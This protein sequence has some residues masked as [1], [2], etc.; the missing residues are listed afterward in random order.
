LA[1]YL[2]CAHNQASTKCNTPYSSDKAVFPGEMS[3]CCWNS[4]CPYFIFLLLSKKEKSHFSFFLVAVVK[5]RNI[6]P[7][8]KSFDGRD[9]AE[10]CRDGREEAACETASRRFGKEIGRKGLSPT[11]RFVL[12]IKASA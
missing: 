2:Y 10:P 5:R 7:P 9:Q 3:G 12:A 8:K 11:A 1:K 4:G 6:F